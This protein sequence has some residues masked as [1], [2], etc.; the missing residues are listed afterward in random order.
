MRKR[1]WIGFARSDQ[2]LQDDFSLAIRS[3]TELGVADASLCNVLGSA[4]EIP[5]ATN[6]VEQGRGHAGL[7]TRTRSTGWP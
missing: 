5:A 7:P 4:Q 2:G 1:S 6:L 3:A